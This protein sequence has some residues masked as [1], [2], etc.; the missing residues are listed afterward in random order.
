MSKQLKA[1]MADT[2][3]KR[4]EGVR[5]ACVVDV[6]HV[7]VQQTVRMR[8]ELT[9]KGM[10][11]HVVKNSQARRAFEGGPLGLL[12]EHLSGPCALVTGGDSIIDVAKEIVRLSEEYQALTPKL[13]LMED[14]SAPIQV[15]D[16]AKFK[17]FAELMSEIAMLVVSPA[18]RLA[19]CLAS[20][21]AKIAGC[22]KALADKEE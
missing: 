7:D 10:R 2:I 12:G 22:L 3:R 18:R 9:A 6:S 5:E 19:A 21:Q 20:P 1:L 15:A 16:L 4:Y 13:A 14:E 8:R 11:L 17:N